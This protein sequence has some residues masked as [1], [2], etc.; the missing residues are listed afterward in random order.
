MFATSIFASQVLADLPVLDIDHSSSAEVEA[1][2][3][4]QSRIQRTGDLFDSDK[5]DLQA[6]ARAAYEETV[7][8]LSSLLGPDAHCA[9]V[10]KDQFNTFS[11]LWKDDFGFSPRHHVTIADVDQWLKERDEAFELGF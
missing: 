6:A 4:E 5:P 8:K 9:Q 3:A 2:Q 11:E 7:Q 10:D 1:T